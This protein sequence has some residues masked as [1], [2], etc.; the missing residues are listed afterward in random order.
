MLKIYIHTYIRLGTVIQ[1][2]K[3]SNDVV[4]HYLSQKHW[5]ALCLE[6]TH[7][8]LTARGLFMIFHFWVWS[9]RFYG[10]LWESHNNCICTCVQCVFTMVIWIWTCICIHTSTRTKLSLLL[11]LLSFISILLWL[12]DLSRQFQEKERNITRP[13]LLSKKK[14]SSFNR[15]NIEQ[16]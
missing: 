8:R 1:L 5:R 9:G 10:V 3:G 14:F 6:L 7:T 2:Y 11:S 16:G 12:Y 4:T 13:V 15:E